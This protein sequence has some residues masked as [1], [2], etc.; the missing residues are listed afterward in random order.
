MSGGWT[1]GGGQIPFDNCKLLV[2]ALDHKPMDRILTDRPANLA[3]EFLHTRHAF[4]VERWLGKPSIAAGLA[5]RGA[6]F[7]CARSSLRMESSGR[8][9]R[10]LLMSQPISG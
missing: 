5:W 3:S 7:A 4:S 2:C 10:I 1:G 8:K 6:P 9:V